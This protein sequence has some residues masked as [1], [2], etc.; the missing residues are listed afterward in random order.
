MTGMPRFGLLVMA[1]FAAGAATVS[2]MAEQ[3]SL[4]RALSSLGTA[5]D[6]LAVTHDNKDGHPAAAIALIDR[7]IAEIRAVG[8]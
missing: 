7:A 2:A 8:Q 3:P 5:R 1:A 4:A 6:Q